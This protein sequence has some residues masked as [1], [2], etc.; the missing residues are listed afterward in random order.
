MRPLRGIGTFLAS[1]KV[2]V[3]EHGHGGEEKWGNWNLD[4]VCRLIRDVPTLERYCRTARAQHAAINGWQLAPNGLMEW[5]KTQLNG[6]IKR[7]Q[8]FGITWSVRTKAKISLK[9]GCC[10]NIIDKDLPIIPIVMVWPSGGSLFSLLFILPTAILSAGLY[11]QC[12]LCYLINV[13]NSERSVYLN[14]TEQLQYKLWLM[15]KY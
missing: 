10:S 14:I 6:E 4:W 5:G 1:W 13:T 12:S 7:E 15:N 2:G 3:G 9:T 11:N 8:R